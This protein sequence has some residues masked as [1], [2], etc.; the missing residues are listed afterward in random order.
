MSILTFLVSFQILTFTS[1]CVI[2][3]ITLPT[4]ASHNTL[5]QSNFVDNKRNAFMSNKKAYL[6][7][8]LQFHLFSTTEN[9]QF[10]NTKCVTEELWV[11]VI[12]ET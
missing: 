4:R 7:T 12:T 8:V 2:K 9:W 10:K 1:A 11:K 5:D 6:Q 3:I